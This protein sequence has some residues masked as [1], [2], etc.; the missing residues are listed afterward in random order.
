MTNDSVRKSSVNTTEAK[1]LLIRTL[2][3]HNGLFTCN[4]MGIHQ[5]AMTG[6]QEIQE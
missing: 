3:K 4:P 6:G 1:G 2:W 5:S